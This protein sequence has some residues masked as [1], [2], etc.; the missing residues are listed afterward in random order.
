MKR[1]LLT[2]GLGFFSS[3]FKRY[4]EQQFE[5]LSTDVQDMDITNAEEVMSKVKAFNPH[6]IIHAAAIASTEFCDQNPDIA[7]R[8]NVEGSLNVAKAAKEVD[9]AMVFIS[10]EQVY[11]GNLEAGPY[12][13]TVMP[14][15]DTVYGQNKLEAEKLLKEFY[16]KVW[17][18]RF[19]WL[20]GL[21]E[22][23][24]GMSPNI[25]WNTVSSLMKG[26]SVKASPHEFRG[27]TYSK[28]MVEQFAKVFEL[29]Y[30]TYN[31]GSDN[32]LSR[33]DIVKLI[34]E[35]LGL[36]ERIPEMLIK[37]DQKYAEKPR[38]VRMDT[39]KIRGLGFSLP[40]T[41]EGIHACIRDFKFK[42]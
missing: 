10:T 1:I 19:T 31:I 39:S 27:M 7:Y 5:I 24:C 6:Y 13:E 21:P 3:R 33:Y 29:P 18:L 8:I 38:D 42:L 2:G 36:Q 34:F 14:V 17:V 26:E 20:L 41:A 9:A 11:N 25:L 28:Y 12:D 35:E 22:A 37:D 16:E 15:P 4:Y 23:G 30:E 40:S 32:E